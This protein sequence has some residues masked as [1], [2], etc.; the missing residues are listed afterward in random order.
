MGI[1]NDWRKKNII[2]YVRK[3][4]TQQKNIGKSV[5]FFYI[6]IFILQNY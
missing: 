5:D 1:Q 4:P 3:N 2:L 6:E